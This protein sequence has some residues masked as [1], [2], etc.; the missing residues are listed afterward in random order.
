[1]SRTRRGVTLIELLVTMVSASVILAGLAS[2]VM[3]MALDQKRALNSRGQAFDRV[4]GLGEIAW[5]LK[6]VGR[7]GVRQARSGAFAVQAVDDPNL[8]LPGGTADAATGVEITGILAADYPLTIKRRGI[9]TYLIDD[10]NQLETQ[11]LQPLAPSPQL[12]D[13]SRTGMIFQHESVVYRFEAPM[14]EAG[15]FGFPPFSTAPPDEPPPLPPGR[16]GGIKLSN[17][18]VSGFNGMGGAAIKAFIESQANRDASEVLAVG[19]DRLEVDYREDPD[20]DGTGPRPRPSNP[21]GIRWEVVFFKS[22]GV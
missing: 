19:V 15:A 9:I 16:P 1:M 3:Q 2:V 10:F 4:R 8:P 7:R 20:P 22:T 13:R 11:P 14:T 5:T 6:Q 21:W 12:P 18:S 17:R